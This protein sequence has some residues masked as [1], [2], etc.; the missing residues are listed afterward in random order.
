MKLWTIEEKNFGNILRSNS[1][2]SP[3]T[4]DAQMTFLKLGQTLQARF[5][6]F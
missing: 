3:P 6:A 4:A 5:F 2:P 1:H